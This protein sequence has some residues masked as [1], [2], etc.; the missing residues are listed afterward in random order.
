MK[1][2]MMYRHGRRM[3]LTHSLW[4]KYNSHNL[5]LERGHRR[6]MCK[7]DKGAEGYEDTLPYWPI[8]SSSLDHTTLC[9]LQ[10]LTSLLFCFPARGHSWPLPH[11][12]PDS[13]S[14]LLT[15]SRPKS[16]DWDWL[17]ARLS[18]SAVGHV[19]IFYQCSRILVVIHVTYFLFFTMVHPA[20]TLLTQLEYPLLSRVNM[21]L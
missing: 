7:R 5:S 21:Q 15:V 13:Q 20:T 8:I 17:P 19:Y 4:K 10:D 16:P 12:T 9:Y 11:W 18:I 1:R 14:L 6:H 2:W 3:I